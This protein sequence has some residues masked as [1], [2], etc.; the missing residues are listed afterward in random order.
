MV[1]HNAVYNGMVWWNTTKYTMVF[2]H[3]DGSIFYGMVYRVL[4]QGLVKHCQESMNFY[5]VC[6]EQQCVENNIFLM[7]KEHHKTEQ[8]SL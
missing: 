1:L 4:S 8:P 5:H 2:L 6:D 7:G 3:S